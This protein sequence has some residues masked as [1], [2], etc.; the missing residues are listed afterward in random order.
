MQRK[1]IKLFNKEYTRITKYTGQCYCCTIKCYKLLLNA[2]H[3][4]VYKILL[5]HTAAN[6]VSHNDHTC[7]PTDTNK[8]ICH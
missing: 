5:I 2:E 7:F 1:P 6:T 4:L 8:Y 3:I